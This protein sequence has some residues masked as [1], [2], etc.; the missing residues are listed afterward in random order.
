MAFLDVGRDFRG[1]IQKM[2]AKQGHGSAA[3]SIDARQLNEA[4]AMPA[5]AYADWGW[6]AIE[7]AAKRAGASA[8]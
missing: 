7:A 4:L 2:V 8:R 1:D 3:P 5:D 6:H